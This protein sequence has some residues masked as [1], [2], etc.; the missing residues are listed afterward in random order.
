MTDG[1]VLGFIFG[2]VFA[3]VSFVV[4]F[5]V[6]WASEECIHRW[7]PWSPPDA[8]GNQDRVCKRCNLHQRTEK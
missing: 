8:E 7:N 4:S 5:K 2:L 3:I 1:F 6:A